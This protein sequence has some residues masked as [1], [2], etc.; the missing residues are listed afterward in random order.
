MEYLDIIEKGLYYIEENL[1]DN[2]TA[3]DISK[4]VGYSSFHFSRLF[5][6]KT[7]ITIGAYISNRKLGIACT[8]LIDTEQ[9]LIDISMSAG[10]KSY[11]AFSRSFKT[12]VGI[13]PYFFRNGRTKYYTF[14][15]PMLDNQM[16]EHL[17]HN[18]SCIPNIVNI[19]DVEVMGMM[20]TTTL[21]NNQLEAL[22]KRFKNTK[23]K[24]LPD[25]NQTK[26]YAICTCRNSVV[27]SDGD[28][29]FSQ[30]LSFENNNH[31]TDIPHQFQKDII[32]G[33]KYAVFKHNTSHKSLSLSYNFIWKIWS[34][35][36]KYKF[37]DTRRSFELYPK[38]YSNIK[39]TPI[40]IY[41]PI[42]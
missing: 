17:E 18:F 14:C 31:H 35:A 36:S 28:S 30:F 7:G 15:N 20:V 39:D 26:Y 16:M 29:C 9:H 24:F 4:A 38:Q 12:H 5:S 23:R 21:F 33:G 10:Y 19:K 22:W 6:K 2:I 32:S 1:E 37:D 34:H 11:E 42:T 13:S 41:I 40:L 3:G 25:E 8:K 27:D